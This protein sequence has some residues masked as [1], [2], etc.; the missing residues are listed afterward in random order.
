MMVS[1]HE[2]YV[3][4]LAEVVNSLINAYEAQVPINLSKIKSEVSKKHKCVLN[5][6]FLIA[7]NK[8][9]G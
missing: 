4:A 5:I 7:F 8:F 3:Q 9:I 1:E 6:N 2:H